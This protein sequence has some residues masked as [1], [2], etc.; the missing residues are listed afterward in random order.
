[1]KN[2]TKWRDMD[3]S[4]NPPE[5]EKQT[6]TMEANPDPLTRRLNA[7]EEEQLPGKNE[8]STTEILPGSYQGATISQ[9]K[10]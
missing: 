9:K 5:K 2:E 1:M 4:L 3:P 10:Q 8:H 6:T 7:E